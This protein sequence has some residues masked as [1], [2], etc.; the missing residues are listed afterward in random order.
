[1]P[2]QNFPWMPEL[3]FPEPTSPTS[4][5]L[6][7]IVYEEDNGESMSLL[8]ALHERR[9]VRDFKS[10]AVERSVIERVLDAAILAPSAMN[11]QPWAFAVLRDRDRIA[12]YSARIKSWLLANFVQT[13]FP[14]ELRETLVK[15]NYAVFHN[16]PA[17]V[18]VLSKSAESQ[19]MEDCCLAAQNLMLAARTEGLGT[20]WIG[21]SR[22]WLN[23]SEAKRELGIP[24]HYHV[25][26]P[27]LLGYPTMWPEAR[28]R[29]AA[30]IH[31]LA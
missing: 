13:G 5:P 16:A 17:L 23:L 19:A 11:R 15:P 12:K 7:P 29:L 30:E 24:D 27:L 20:C 21:L 9:A 28:S 4:A 31:W 14:S 1:M 26:S 2:D 22:T 10:T 8:D 25:V 6:V 3:P 18:L